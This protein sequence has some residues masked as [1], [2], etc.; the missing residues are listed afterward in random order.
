M[1]VLPRLVA[2]SLLASSLHCVRTLPTRHLIFC[3]DLT[4]VETFLQFA[5]WDRRR[6]WQGPSSS[7]IC[8]ELF[9]VMIGPWLPVGFKLHC[10]LPCS[11]CPISI[12]VFTTHRTMDA[13]L[14]PWYFCLYSFS[15]PDCPSLGHQ[16]LS[17]QSGYDQQLRHPTPD[18]ADTCC[19]C[20]FTRSH[21]HWLCS[22]APWQVSL[23]QGHEPG[24]AICPFSLTKVAGVSNI[25]S[26]F[27]PTPE[28]V[29]WVFKP[30]QC[31]HVGLWLGQA[32]R[33]TALSSQ[34]VSLYPPLICFFPQEKSSD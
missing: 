15:S 4:N 3:S 16:S 2:M 23:I 34:M 28:R 12:C 10:S 13:N 22:P 30:T 7:F 17:V 20:G 32:T 24:Q 6:S 19:L 18:T 21:C 26:Q 25:P 11:S 8:Q 14:C 31:L 33:L 5:K 9:L 1:R 29:S 27:T